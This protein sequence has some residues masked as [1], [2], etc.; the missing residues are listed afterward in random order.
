[1]GVRWRK[2]QEVNTMAREQPRCMKRISQDPR[3]MVGKPVV[4]GTRIPVELVLGHL[5]ENPDLSDLFGTY[6]EFELDDVKAV[7]AYAQAMVGR[8]RVSKRR[9]LEAALASQG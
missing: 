7:L 9:A 1:M 2:M 6:P 3:V 4:A 8:G 5:A